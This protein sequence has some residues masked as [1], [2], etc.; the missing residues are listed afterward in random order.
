MGSLSLLQGNLLN[1]GIKPR[2]PALQ[3]DSFPSEPSG[4]S[5]FVLFLAGLGL[6]RTGFSL[7]AGCGLLTALPSLVVERGL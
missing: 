5:F 4:K 3:V 6:H 2:S 1:P 7:V